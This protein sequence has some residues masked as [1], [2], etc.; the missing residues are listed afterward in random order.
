LQTSHDGGAASTPFNPSAEG[1]T[2]TPLNPSA[3][4]STHYAVLTEKN[5][6][7]KIKKIKKGNHN[8]PYS[9]IIIFIFY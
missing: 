4:T 8:V 5:K 2:S 6:N 7:K 1:A 9:H 3:Q